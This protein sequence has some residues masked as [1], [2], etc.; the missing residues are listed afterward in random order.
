M[1]TMTINQL[2]RQP[3]KQ[4][5]ALTLI[6]G[7]ALGLGAF[8]APTA[9]AQCPEEAIAQLEKTDQLLM[10]VREI[11]MEHAVDASSATAD[12][13]ESLLRIA[14][15]I[16]KEAKRNCLA[17]H[18]VIAMRLTREARDKAQ[19]ALGSLNVHD[20]NEPF[21]ERQLQKTDELLSRIREHVEEDVPSELIARLER[22]HE[23]QRRAW[24]LFRS[25]RPRMAL[26]LSGEAERVARSI[27][28]DA[29]REG[30]LRE[31]LENRYER[32]VDLISHIGESVGECDNEAAADLLYNAQEALANSERLFQERHY[33]QAE[34]S[35]KRARELAQKARA[36]CGT[37]ERQIHRLETLRSRAEK[38]G[39]RAEGNVEARKLIESAWNNLQEAEELIDQGMYT[40]SAGQLKAAELLLRQARQQLGR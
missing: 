14:I 37:R 21:V 19:A 34:Q 24:E 15:A 1:N 9:S 6:L 39:E 40:A 30:R 36:Q 38:L 5:L 23:L 13:S 25:G 4:H 20:E 35:L 7:I 31:G 33:R 18:P 29:Q 8:I 32:V 3:R 22:A 11:L 12:R 10:R 27:I 26:K 28:Q 2:R 17:G 16:Q